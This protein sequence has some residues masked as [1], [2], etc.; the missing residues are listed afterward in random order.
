MSP[1]NVK[2]VRDWI[3]KY[4]PQY[5]CTFCGGQN[6]SV[7]DVVMPALPKSSLT[8]GQPMVVVQCA[9]CAHVDLFD[10]I[11]VGLKPPFS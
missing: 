5:H 10:A 1:A 2:T 11:S 6:W 7:G 4:V 9:I 8:T 3:M